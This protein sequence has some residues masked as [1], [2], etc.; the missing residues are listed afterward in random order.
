MAR[1]IRRSLA[2]GEVGGIEE[3]LSIQAPANLLPPPTWH[4]FSDSF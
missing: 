3:E 1:H 4:C 2:V